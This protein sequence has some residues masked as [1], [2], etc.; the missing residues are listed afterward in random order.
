MKWS[1]LQRWKKGKEFLLFF[2]HCKK[3]PFK[4]CWSKFHGLSLDFAVPKTSL[5]I[6]ELFADQ[7]WTIYLLIDSDIATQRFMVLEITFA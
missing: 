4:N 6:V 5:G 7:I 3:Y 2:K 1:A